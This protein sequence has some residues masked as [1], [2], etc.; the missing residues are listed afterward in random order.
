M[1]RKTYKGSPC[2]ESSKSNVVNKQPNLFFLHSE[3]TVLPIMT[4]GSIVS[5]VTIE[6]AIR[7]TTMTFIA[8]MFFRW[9][10]MNQP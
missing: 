3:I 1:S 2:S 10:S 6:D 4:A 8:V 5:R 9:P 7:G